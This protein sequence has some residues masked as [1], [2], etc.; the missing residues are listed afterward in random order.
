MSNIIKNITLG[1]CC[2]LSVF[3]KS[4]F[5]APEST[6]EN[7]ELGRL[8]VE[9]ESKKIYDDPTWLRLLHFRVTPRIANH[10]DIITPEFFNAYDKSIHA[11]LKPNLAT[12]GITSKQELIATL[13]AFYQPI[14][15][16]QNLHPQCRFPARFFW[17]NTKLNFQDKQL[18]KIVC[19]R[20]EK[21][22][23]FQ[24]LNSISLI[25]VSGYFGNP[26]STFGHLLVKLNNSEFKSS[27]GNLLDQSINYGAKVPPNEK[28]PVYII[29]GIFGGYVAGF[30]DNKFYTQ[31]LVYSKQE[32]RDMWEYELN[33]NQQQ[34][35]LLVYHIW[36]M[37][38]MKS[39]YYFLKENC[40]YRI[41]ELLELV[42]GHSLTPDRQPWYL[43]V[44]V[45]QELDEVENSRYI[46]KITFFPSSQRQLHHSFNQLSNKEASVVNKILA[47][48]DSLKKH[49]VDN[50]TVKQTSRMLEVML[51]Y[52]RYKISGEDIS[53]KQKNI[54][55]QHK[56]T[57]IVERLNLPIQQRE[58]PEKVPHII[59]PAKGAK[60]RLF[61]VGI[62]HNQAHGEV[63]E[64]GLTAI[65]YDL[66]SNSKGSLE[67]SELTLFNLILNYDKK[68][69]FSVQKFDLISIKKLGL[70]S[71]KLFGESN[72]S[73]RIRTGFERN[74]LSCK[75]CTN[76]F[77]EGGIGHAYKLR[78][79]LISY[80]MLDGRYSAEKNTF[81]VAPNI[82]LIFS[83]NKKLKSV[84][85][86]GTRIDVESGQKNELLKLETRYSLSKNNTLRLSFEKNRG[87]EFKASFY[88]NW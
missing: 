21:W 3:C 77:I 41:A 68:Q 52:Y 22:A 54:L 69:D 71:T 31:D 48:P 42:T 74:D 24:T 55:K 76:F 43:P 34:N 35:R 18:P 82:G 60:P 64:L 7:P 14:L 49:L 78:G 13:N 1:F 19:G 79:N 23:K 6:D 50:F 59:S 45:F 86:A 80:G 62:A 85:E 12:R 53:E 2:L 28:L 88:H 30:S 27:S 38:G 84:L 61:H 11:G 72:L 70:N 73:W 51:D 20:L 5:A 4:T 56:N 40:G 47:Y 67:N 37:V 32:Y 29:K 39:T 58:K 10:S 26:A 15:K 16:D 33:L 63:Y 81:E 83:N 65:H 8:L 66:L 44:S 46:K 87:E 9:A 17:L 36:E 25:M 57:L 75:N